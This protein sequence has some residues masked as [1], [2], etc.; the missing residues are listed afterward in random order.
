MFTWDISK[1]KDHIFL[2]RPVAQRAEDIGAWY[3]ILSALTTL[4]VIINAFILAFTSQLIPS[5]VYR[6]RSSP[7]HT[8]RGYVDWTLSYF[9][10]KDFTNESRPLDTTVGGIPLQEQCRYPGYREPFY[11][12]NR[13][14]KYWIILSCRLAFVLCFVV[15][16]FFVAWLIDLI[17]REVPSTLEMTIKREKYLAT[18]ADKDHRVKVGKRR[19][20]VPMGSS[21]VLG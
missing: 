14:T 3:N 11:P 10:V 18:Q 2:R 16:V 5:L 9:N 8:M 17:V 20:V 4:S 6:Y 7:D 21:A 15:F 13:N 1:F 12:Y 19:E